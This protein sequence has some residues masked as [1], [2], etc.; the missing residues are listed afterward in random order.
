MVG[1]IQLLADTFS[2]SP[3]AIGVKIG[4]PLFISVKI[5]KLLRIVRLLEVE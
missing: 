3:N 2:L 5:K 1:Q 4:I